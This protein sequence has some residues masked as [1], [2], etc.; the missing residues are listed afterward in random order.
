MVVQRRSCFSV[1]L[2]EVDARDGGS[3]LTVKADSLCTYAIRM[4]L[5]FI[6]HFLHYSTP[7]DTL[8]CSGKFSAY[9]TERGGN[10]LVQNL[11]ELE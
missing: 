1:I 6:P 8:P 3:G 4:R 5:D 9:Q 7:V 11:M 2:D 10:N